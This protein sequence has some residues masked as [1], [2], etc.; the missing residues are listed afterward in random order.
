MCPRVIHEPCRTTA[1]R[2]LS[3]RFGDYCGPLGYGD[4]PHPMDPEGPRTQQ[5]I[6]RAFSIFRADAVF[7]RGLDSGSTRSLSAVAVGDA[8]LGDLLDGRDD[9]RAQYRESGQFQ[10]SRA[11]YARLH[12]H[13][14]GSDRCLGCARAD[15]RTR[16]SRPDLGRNDRIILWWVDEL[17]GRVRRARCSS[18]TQRRRLSRGHHR[19]Q[20][21]FGRH[22]DARRAAVRQAFTA[23]VG[24]HF[25]R[26][27]QRRRIRAKGSDTAYHFRLYSG[28]FRVLRR[29]SRFAAAGTSVF[30]IHL[31]PGGHFRN[32]VRA[33]VGNLDAVE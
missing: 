12:G 3:G 7:Q 2:R 28:A 8:L 22:A 23:M 19:I 32:H 18:F 10:D 24:R 14:G 13:G 26:R 20:L 33:D 1:A 4:R 5:D 29:L 11:V 31:H 25:D 17:G 30:A 21:L 27:T 6:F 9:R 15:H 16:C